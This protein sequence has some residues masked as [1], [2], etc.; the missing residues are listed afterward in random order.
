MAEQY[1]AIIIGAGVIG[2]CTAFELA[3]KGWKTLNIDKLPEAGY[4]STSGSC[5]IIRTYY[6][7]YETCAL[8]YEGWFYW[9]DWANYI[10]TDDDQGLI[11]YHDTGC[12]VIK[13]E[14][15]KF[16]EQAC[17]T[18]DRI[19]CPYEH[20]EPED[21]SNKLPG[22]DIRKFEPA[23]RIEDE[24]F[25][26]PTGGEVP[27]AVLFK[28]GGYVSDPKLSAHNAQRAAE[29][30]GGKF[31]FN[32]EVSEIR[33]ANGRVTG[34]TLSDGTRIDAKV[35]INVAGPHSSII[36]GMAGV[37][38]GMKMTT[39][40]LRHE[41]AHVPAP[42]D[43]DYG[44]GGFVYSD[45]DV[46]TYA[47]S[48]IGN[49]ILIGSE[50]PACDE[51]E[52]VDDPDNYNTEFTDQNKTLVMRFAQRLP[53]LGI[54]EQAKGVV[55]LYDVTEDWIPIYDKSDLPGFYMACGTSGNQFKNAPVAGKM[56][57][58]IIEACENGHDHDTDPIMFELENI[59]H[60]ISLGTFSRNREI[61]PN[62]SFSVIG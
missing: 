2:A 16:L 11:K 23:K 24:A 60:T 38:D 53:S 40:A 4:G 14:H 33:Q 7:A 62:S 10:G 47:R 32:T 51:K 3:K 58:A 13:T 61:N 49:H 17:E 48:E 37:R 9:K 25:G 21:I 54:P 12:L 41:V 59:G 46:S 55:A 52:W 28:A 1:D 29:A 57:T 27:G 20:V 15:N 43:I 44:N 42:V 19:G 34:V 50:D 45:S 6:S 35:V 36:N 39:R 18:M 8:A 22:A 56:M 5:A 26:E 31:R 30:H